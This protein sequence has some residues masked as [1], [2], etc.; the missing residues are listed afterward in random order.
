MVE[1]Q[2]WLRRVADQIVDVRHK[3]RAS[4]HEGPTELPDALKQVRVGITRGHRHLVVRED[5]LRHEG[6]GYPP[7]MEW[8]PP[9]L[10]VLDLKAWRLVVGRK[11]GLPVV[12][13]ITAGSGT[14]VDFFRGIHGCTV[15]ASDLAGPNEHVG[16]ADARRVGEQGGHLHSVGPSLK[17]APRPDLMLFDPP[18]RG[19]PTHGATYF[20]GEEQLDLALLD[21]DT[22]L[23]TLA[24]IT[25]KSA[26][27]LKPKGLV[28]VFLRCCVRD[29]QRIDPDHRLVGDFLGALEALEPALVVTETLIV[30][31]ATDG[32][33]RQAGVHTAR[34]KAVR[35]LIARKS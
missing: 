8:T 31:W 30:T 22:Y 20:C 34:P 10:M 6:L 19:T 29:R 2:R 17:A 24:K 32:R 35:I 21:R 13:D 28:S 18:S 23:G 1:T 25:A 9:E 26:A 12:H 3:E 5:R 33:V 16:M 7:Y 4:Q 15:V 27:V 11:T 14:S